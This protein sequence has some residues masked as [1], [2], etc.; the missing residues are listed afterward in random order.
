MKSSN[1]VLYVVIAV[2]A[3]IVSMS[4]ARIASEAYTDLLTSLEEAA[5]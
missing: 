5:R 4:A 3:V 1:W 2:L